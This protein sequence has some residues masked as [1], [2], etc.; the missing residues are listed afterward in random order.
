MVFRL[1]AKAFFNT[2]PKCSI[3][4]E[5]VY[6]QYQD[7]GTL[8]YIIIANELHADGTPHIHVCAIFDRKKNFIAPTCFDLMLDGVTYHGNYTTAR[9]REAA[10]QYC[11]KEDKTPF[12][13]S[14][15]KL[16]DEEALDDIFEQ[17][18]TLSI[19]EFTIYC[20]KH[21][22]SYA[23]M[24]FILTSIKTNNTIHEE[25]AG[26][27]FT[28]EG[29]FKI[30]LNDSNTI[31]KPTP[32]MTLKQKK[33]KVQSLN[34]SSWWDQLD[35]EKLLGQSTV[36]QDQSSSL[37]TSIHSDYST[38]PSTNQYSSMTCP[39]PIFLEKAKSIWST[40]NSQEASIVDTQLPTCPQDWLKHLQPIDIHSQQWNPP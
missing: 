18:K 23:Y 6:A 35:V 34:P 9:K 40:Q 22:V 39:S 36:C 12:T 37:L 15:E 3:P 31:Q 24:N 20:L 11:K 10:I 29:L 1:S 19:E 7:L 16:T 2:Y 38:K 27:A 32:F 14:A 33:R 4:K 21:K 26:T 30:E 25:S 8:E 5:I 28:N 13:Y 17:A